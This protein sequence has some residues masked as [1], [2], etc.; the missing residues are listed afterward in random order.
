MLSHFALGLRQ[1]IVYSFLCASEK[2]AFIELWEGLSSKSPLD[3]TLNSCAGQRQ[4]WETKE[5]LV[6]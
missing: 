5:E 2:A 6:E 3:M 4:S 1:C